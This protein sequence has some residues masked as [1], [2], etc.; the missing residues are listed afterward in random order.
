MKIVMGCGGELAPR[1][2]RT[3]AG[4]KGIHSSAASSMRLSSCAGVNSPH[5]PTNE[6]KASQQTD[7]ASRGQR[8]MTSATAAATPIQ[9]N[10]VIMAALEFSHNKVGALKKASIAEWD[11]RVRNNEAAGASPVG[12]RIAFPSA[13]IPAK[14]NTYTRPTARRTNQ[15]DQ[16]WAAPPPVANST[17]CVHGLVQGLA[18]VATGAVPSHPVPLSIQ[19]GPRPI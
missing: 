11:A 4:A 3:P 5:A 7:N 6:R 12:P 14:T 10:A 13:T 16:R 2:G 8:F 18:V 17:K 1:P 15:R 9:P 19:S